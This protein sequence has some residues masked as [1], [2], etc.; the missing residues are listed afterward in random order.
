LI[1]FF[2]PETAYIR[3]PIERR[4]SGAGLPVSDNNKPAAKDGK[5]APDESR[6]SPQDSTVPEQKD[7]Y[8]R[9]LRFMTGRNIPLLR[10]GRF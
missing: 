5:E 2:V 1:F 9:S 10:S 7:S 4:L 8:L 6:L 3:D